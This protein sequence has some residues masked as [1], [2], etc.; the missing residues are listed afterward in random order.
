MRDRYE[1]V[2][3]GQGAAGLCAA[4]A[5]AE[6]AHNLGRNCAITL[7]DSASEEA[8]GGNTRWSPSNMRMRSPQALTPGFEEDVQQASGGRADSAYFRRLAAESP[9]TVAWLQAHGIAFHSPGYYISA[10]PERIQPVGGGA[11][12]VRE[13]VR[14]AKAAGVEFHYRMNAERLMRAENGSITGVEVR[15]AKGELRRIGGGAVILACGGFEGNAAMLREYFGPGA[16]DMRLVS[17]GTAFNTGAGIRM[18]LECGALAAGDWQGM[19]AEPVDPRSSTAQALALVYP[20][21]VVV[22]RNGKRFFDEGA[23]LVHETWETFARHIH[24]STPG[25]IAFAVLDSALYDIANYQKAI[26]S[27]VPPYRGATIRELALVAG[28][29]ADGLARTLAEYNAAAA[30]DARRFDASRADGLAAA[31]GL[32]P[33]KSNWARALTRPPYL[34]Y[35]LVGA[36]VYTFGGIATNDQAEVLDANGAIPGLYAAG[37]ITGHFHGLAPNAVATMRALVYGRIAGI[38]AMRAGAS[39]AAHS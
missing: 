33:P 12:I 37:E 8:S 38:N 34:A 6:E 7:I 19:H 35:P 31:P 39:P 1:L 27:E 32:V 13:L 9:A 3:V 5:A 28:I 22:D 16:E 20:Y 15:T 21:G 17:P 11:V 14:A 25:R 30:G 29:D 2:V 36:V 18:A 26:K 4:L 23:G 24:F 10:G